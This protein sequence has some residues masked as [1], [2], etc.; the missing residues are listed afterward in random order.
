MQVSGGVYY[1]WKPLSPVKVR[2]FIALF[3]LQGLSPSLQ[4]KI[5][6]V[7]QHEDPINGSNIC[8]K[9]F[10]MFDSFFACQYPLKPV[11]SKKNHP[12][13]KVDPF[14]AHIQSISIKAWDM[15][16]NISCDEQTIGFTGNQQRIICTRFL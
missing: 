8:F 2:Q 10:K 11:P 5:K 13:F 15:E 6:F 7:P 3:I 4:M 12:N 9:V 16:Q 14:L 1:D